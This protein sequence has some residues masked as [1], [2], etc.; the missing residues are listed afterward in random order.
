MSGG[1]R[2]AHVAVADAVRRVLGR[3]DPLAKDEQDRVRECADLGSERVNGYRLYEDFYDG[4][5]RT[6]LVDRAWTYLEASTG[7]KFCENIVETAIDKAARRFHVSG[8]QVEDDEAASDWLTQRLWGKQNELQGI[9]HSEVPKLGD[10]FVAV[11]WDTRR[12]RPRLTWNRPHLCKAVYDEDGEGL[13]TVKK[14]STTRRGPQNELGRLVWRLNIYYPDRVEK[15]FS[16]D[17]EGEQWAPWQDQGDTAWPVPW[18]VSGL[19]PANGSEAE[20]GLGILLKHFREKPKGRNYGRSRVRSMIPYQNELN[21][22]VLDLF[23][24]MDAQGW[25]RQWVTGVSDTEAIKYAIGDILRLADKDAKVGQLD[26]ADPR[27]SLEAIDATMR[28]FS[29][30]TD[31]PL[32]DLIK[33]TPPSGEAL[34]TAVMG[35]TAY[36]EDSQATQ[37]HTWEATV[38][39]GWHLASLYGDDTVPT[40]NAEADVTTQWESTEPRSEEMEAQ[41]SIYY[42]ELGVSNATLMRRHGFDPTEEEKLRALEDPELP[43]VPPPGA[44]IP[45]DE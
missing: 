11:T 40:F 32:F 10:G 28:R 7:V 44:R 33:G 24:V 6:M 29:A 26:S 18:T 1:D 13:Y 20:D 36:V 2:T 22:Q 34:K 4:Q 5:Q 21:K 41:T 27:P 42:R 45:V 23:Y 3:G 16:A 30:K 9:V 15:W 19:L 31:T 17:S 37:G 39:L 8:F 25:P 38:S 35:Q 12:K 43:A 14:W